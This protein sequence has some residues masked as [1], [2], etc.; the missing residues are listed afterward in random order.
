M[1]PQGMNSPGPRAELLYHFCRLQL[2]SVNLPADACQRHLQRTFVLYEKKEP[3]KASW[4]QYLDNLYPLD[5]F[6][7]SSCLEGNSRAWEVLFASRAG[8]SDC[9]L[10]D[11]LRARAA[12]LYPRDDERQESAVTEFWSHLYVPERP[13]SL[14]VLARFDGLRPL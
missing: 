11:A 5:W 14:A 3:E 2:P 8:R 10:L 6:V 7:A 13:G 1:M 9:L 4:D 12:R